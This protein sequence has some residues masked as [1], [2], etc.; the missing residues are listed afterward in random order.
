MLLFLKGSSDAEFTFICS[1]N[2]NVCWE[3]VHIHPIMI[4]IQCYFFI[5]NNNDH[6]L[7]SVL[8]F[9][10]EWCSSAKAPPTIVDW[11]WCFNIDP[12]WVSCNSLPLFHRRSRCR[13]ECFSKRL[14]CFVVGCNDE[15]STP[16]IWA[17]EDTVDYVCDQREC[18]PDL[19]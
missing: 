6:F 14:R 19:P 7:R 10:A 13:Q 15:H 18:N 11:Q 2:I 9:L 12:P 17:A 16:D 4:Q 5:P 3:C 8:R 1:L